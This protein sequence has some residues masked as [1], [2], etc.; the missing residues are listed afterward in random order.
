[1]LDQDE[2]ITPSNEKDIKCAIQKCDQKNEDGKD[3]DVSTTAAGGPMP[4]GSQCSALGSKK[5]TCVKKTL[6]KKNKNC[7]CEKTFDMNKTPP[8]PHP[9][10]A[11]QL[12]AGQGRRPD[13]VVGGP[14]PQSY[15]VYDAK[16]PCSASVKKSVPT[17][18]IPMPSDMTRSGPT[19][20][21]R[22]QRDA[23]KAVANGGKVSALS[24]ADCA[25]E[26]CDD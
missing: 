25:S 22:G 11:P 17:G 7:Q 18:P 23:Y 3:Y 26:E 13:V 6:E 20:M 15:D 24:P 8:T 14:P 9:P 5:H 4:P 1:M 19:M 12:P 2:L 10:G 21:G 16:F